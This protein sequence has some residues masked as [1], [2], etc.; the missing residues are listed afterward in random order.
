MPTP[1]DIEITDLV[2]AARG[3][4][5]EAA[6]ILYEKY[7]PTILRAIRRKFDRR[8]QRIRDPSDF[9]Q[10]A[11]AAFFAQKAQR[12]FDTAQG[13]AAYLK[14]IALNKVRNAGQKYLRS[15]RSNMS[16]DVSLQGTPAAGESATFPERE[17]SAFDEAVK[18][19][20]LAH[21]DKLPLI[22]RQIIACWAYGRKPAAIAQRLHVGVPFVYRCI[23]SAKC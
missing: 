22:N 11:F 1:F 14:K 23:E 4:S 12:P 8:L 21:Y 15:K 6:S 7:A 3:G 19:R 16:N 10:D 17:E 5:D 9:L 13:F 18:K 20:V 2:R